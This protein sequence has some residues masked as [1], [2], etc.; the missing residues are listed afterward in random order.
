MISCNFFSVNQPAPKE[1]QL[2]SFESCLLLTSKLR[3]IQSSQK[4]KHRYRH[5]NTQRA[6]LLRIGR[7]KD[8]RCEGLTQTEL[9]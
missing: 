7:S 6:D 2:F 5:K 4:Q 8:A 9:L 1:I 3:G